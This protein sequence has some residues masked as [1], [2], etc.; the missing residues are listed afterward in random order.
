ML[1]ALLAIALTADPA[2]ARARCDRAERAGGRISAGRAKGLLEFAPP[3]GTGMTAACACATPTGSKGE[4]LTFTR[5]SSG[6]CLT[7]GTVTGIANGS[8][9][10]CT[11]NQPRVMPGG[12]G[13]GGPGLLMESARTNLALRSQELENAVYVNFVGTG[14]TNPVVTANA[15]VAPDGTTTADRHQFADSPSP[16]ASMRAQTLLGGAG[17]GVCSVFLKG[18][19][20]AGTMYLVKYNSGAGTFDVALCSYN[21]FTWTRCATLAVNAAATVGNCYFGNDGTG[22]FGTNLGAIDVFL[23][24]LQFEAGTSASS[25]VSTAGASVTRAAETATFPIAAGLVNTAGSTAATV[26][27]QTVSAASGGMV[28]FAAANRPLRADFSGAAGFS[29]RDGPTEVF[30]ANGATANTAVRGYSFWSAATQT[31]GTPTGQTAG[32]FDGDMMAGAVT[33]EIGNNA[34]GAGALGGV[35][36]QVCLDPNPARCR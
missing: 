12:D 27:L 25:Y 31:I 19:G 7:G 16:K 29:V 20:T 36:K 2:C 18:N 5:A 4:V 32:V 28:T 24:G 13:T 10:T 15:A 8:M 23:W 14:G 34:G 33:L 3:E 21:A 35:I 26:L 22:Q 30:R 11:D 17:H 6:T 1:L 9:V